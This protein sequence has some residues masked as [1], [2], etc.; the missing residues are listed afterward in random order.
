MAASQGVCSSTHSVE[1]IRAYSSAS[2]EAKTLW[3]SQLGGEWWYG[4]DLHVS[5]WLPTCF[6]QLSES[7]G[8]FDQDG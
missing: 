8:D 2:Q 6:Q 5:A 7:F 1:P 3:G 4:I